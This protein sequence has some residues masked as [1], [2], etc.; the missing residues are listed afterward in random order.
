MDANLRRCGRFGLN[1][2][3]QC[4]SMYI[5]GKRRDCFFPVRRFSV[6]Q[7]HSAVLHSCGRNKALVVG[8]Q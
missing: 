4:S 2:A 7:Y 8:Q 3:F 6:M 5:F 1:T